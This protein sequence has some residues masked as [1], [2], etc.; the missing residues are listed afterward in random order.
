MEVELPRSG[1][2][3]RFR[4]RIRR[5]TCAAREVGRRAFAVSRAPIGTVGAMLFDK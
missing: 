5:P 1:P 2:D 3:V 4:E